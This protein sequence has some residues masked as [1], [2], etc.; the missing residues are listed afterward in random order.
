MSMGVTLIV[1]ALAACGHASAAP[2]H[3]TT[4]APVQSVPSELLGTWQAVGQI[5]VEFTQKMVLSAKGFAFYSA[6]PED[7]AIGGV[8]AIGANQLK[9]GPNQL[10]CQSY[11]TYTWRL[12][13]GKLYFTGGDGDPCARAG[14]LPNYPW[15]K[16]SDS[17]S[18]AD[19]VT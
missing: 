16:I 3:P 8:Q 17:Q 14:I 5:D 13:G 18:P 6:G 11:G 10:Q 9:F 12:T 2:I 1:T 19:T 4:S 15:E 7:S